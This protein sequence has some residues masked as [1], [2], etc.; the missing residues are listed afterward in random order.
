VAAEDL[1]YKHPWVQD[2][3]WTVLYRCEPLLKGSWLRGRALREV[4]KHVHYEV[5]SFVLLVWVEERCRCAG[6][7]RHANALSGRVSVWRS[8]FPLSF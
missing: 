3:V 7:A 8:F 5:R 2:V 4:M 6:A 1:Y